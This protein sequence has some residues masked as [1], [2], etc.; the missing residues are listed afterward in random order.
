MSPAPADGQ[1]G[2]RP[3]GSAGE[4]AVKAAPRGAGLGAERQDK[5]VAWGHLLAEGL[6]GQFGVASLAGQQAGV[7]AGLDDAA[8]VEHDDLVGVAD[9]G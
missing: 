3:S 6:C 1:A 8:V 9:G 2:F 4:G 5:T 7:V